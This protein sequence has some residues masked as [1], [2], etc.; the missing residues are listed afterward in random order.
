MGRKFQVCVN[1]AQIQAKIILKWI[2][3]DRSGGGN[4]AVGRR[5]EAKLARTRGQMRLLVATEV[6]SMLSLV[7]SSFDL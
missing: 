7:F 6:T 5:D 2:V 3:R 1:S 4:G